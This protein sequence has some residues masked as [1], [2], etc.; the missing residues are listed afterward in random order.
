MNYTKL[1]NS[2]F[3]HTN[4]VADQT[5][6][7]IITK[8]K[9]LSNKKNHPTI[10][11]AFIRNP[12]VWYY[13]VWEHKQLRDN[14]PNRINNHHGFYFSNEKELEDF[15]FWLYNVLK[16][17]SATNYFY[18]KIK[19][20]DIIGKRENLKLDIEK[21]LKACEG[22]DLLIPSIKKESIG[23]VYNKKNIK[24]V[25]QNDYEFL[26]K[27]EYKTEFGEYKKFMIE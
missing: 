20:C 23:K 27:Y 15:N 7:F 24:R 3:I 25:L 9:L 1:K 6:K 8:N 19:S 5:I 2:I 14:F 16:R 18:S 12:F 21:I 17:T 10:S 11:F 13:K 4:R 22:K 26:K